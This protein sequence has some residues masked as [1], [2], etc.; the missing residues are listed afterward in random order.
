M[1]GNTSQL[2]DCLLP[3]SRRT[4]PSP[5]FFR[6]IGYDQQGKILNDLNKIGALARDGGAYLQNGLA[7]PVEPEIQRFF[8]EV[9]EQFTLTAALVARHLTV[10]LGQLRPA[11]RTTLDAAMTEILDILKR[12]G[13]NDNI[14]RNAYIKFMCWLRG[15]LGGILKGLGQDTPPKVL[16]EGEIGR[17]ELLFL[18]LLYRSGCD[19]VYVNYCSEDSYTKAARGGTYGHPIYGEV[20]TPPAVPPASKSASASVP[21]AS[22]HPSGSSATAGRFFPRSSSLAGCRGSGAGQPLDGWR[23]L[24]G[25]CFPA[26]RTAGNRKVLFSIFRLLWGQRPGGIP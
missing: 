4:P 10:W 12:Q 23:F 3:L 21:K 17:Y 15:P 7:N 19:V 18:Q 26:L 1:T 14:C 22:S 20:R 6:V 16:Y 8:R 24:L 2:E 5:R 25:R 13:A 9:G 11:Q